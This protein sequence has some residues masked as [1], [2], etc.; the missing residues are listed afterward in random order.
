MVKKIIYLFFI[1]LNTGLASSQNTNDAKKDTVEIDDVYLNKP[2]FKKGKTVYLRFY[3]ALQNNRTSHI[4]I[5]YGEGITEFIEM[6]NA[7]E[8]NS[9]VNVVRLHFVLAKFLSEG[10]VIVNSNSSGMDYLRLT[11]FLLQKNN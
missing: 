8:I 6:R 11:T 1:V 10:Y 4:I 3:E 9:T 7:K 2:F 5:S